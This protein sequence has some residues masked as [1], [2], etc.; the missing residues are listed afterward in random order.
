MQV[1]VKREDPAR[2]RTDALIVPLSKTERVPRALQALD[3]ALGRRIQSYLEAA[4]F[5]GKA[6]ELVAFPAEG[7]AAK[8]V[9]LVGLGT[10][11]EL[12]AEALRRAAGAG[13][14]A[15]ARRRAASVALVVP[16]VR[17]LAPADRAQALTEGGLL[18]A[19]RFDRYRELE[20]PRGPLDELVLLSAD[21]REGSAL[22]R[23]VKQGRI[24]AESARLA[25]DLSNEPGSVHT[26]EWMADQARKL[27]REV[28]LKVKVLAERELEREKMQGILSVGRGSSNPPRLIVLEHNA[29]A[30]GARRRPTL[31]LVGKGITFDSGGISIKPAANMH[32]MKHDMSGGAAVFGALRGAAL[33][34][35]PQHVVGIVPVAQNMPG[36]GAYLPGDIV[37]AASGKTIEVL[38]TDAEGRIVLADALHHA[39]R[40]KPD[41]I[42][43]LATLTGACVIALGSACC[44]V[45]GNNEP[46][47]K[48]VQAAGD[49]SHERAWP[50]P[51]WDEHKK[52]IKGD[53]G[54]IKN[55]GG[56]EAGASTAA[57]F[58]SHFVGATPW[59]HLDIAGTAWTTREQP[60]CVKGATGF[61]VRL[62]LELLRDWSAL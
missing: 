40:F 16:S 59:A 29:P 27:G 28:G 12:N 30:D 58:L 41:A 57:A 44:A 2:A 26:P 62:L 52:Q 60:Y 13:I 10:E 7:I 18:G 38:N 43:D 22:R 53:V 3:T 39:Q 50:L 47:I 23:G 4:E 54:D 9:I 45:M 55:T 19:Y 14:K 24:A 33:L 35:L 17:R 56:R 48:R 11:E 6:A 1:E 8:T 31:A 5:R 25:R 46:L 51:L 32:E 20:E 15:A 21:A 34:G 36:A 49:R 42:V 37:R 61:G